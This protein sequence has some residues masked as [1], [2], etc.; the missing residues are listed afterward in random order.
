M[1]MDSGLELHHCRALL[2]AE[3]CGSQAPLLLLKHTGQEGTAVPSYLEVVSKIASSSFPETGVLLLG[4]MKCGLPRETEPMGH[5]LV[6]ACICTDR[7]IW[8]S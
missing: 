4:A 5:V 1:H 7:L 8:W 3:R 6:F 2:G